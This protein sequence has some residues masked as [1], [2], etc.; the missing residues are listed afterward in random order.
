[1]SVELSDALFPSLRPSPMV[2]VSMDICLTV[3]R[4]AVQNDIP[5]V[6]FSLTFLI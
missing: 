1:M 2:G 3:A 4:T 6:T 5:P